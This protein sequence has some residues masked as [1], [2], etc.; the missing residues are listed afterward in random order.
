MVCRGYVGG[1]EGGS[2]G[3]YRS[4][5]CIGI[6]GGSQNLEFPKMQ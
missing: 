6:C 2:I 4:R 1:I 5:G 3:V